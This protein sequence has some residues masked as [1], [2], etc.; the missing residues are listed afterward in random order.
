MEPSETQE[1]S[2][3]S[4]DDK[5]VE[6]VKLDKRFGRIAVKNKLLTIDQVK[7]ALRKQDYIYKKSN[8]IVLIGDLLVDSGAMGERYRDAI[9]KRQ[10]RLFKRFKSFGEIAVDKGFITT[11]QLENAL[12]IQA[13]EYKESRDV[14]ILGDI[15]VSQELIDEEQR[16]LIVME[17]NRL[18]GDNQPSLSENTDRSETTQ[19][20]QTETSEP[21]VSE[22]IQSQEPE[23]PEAPDEPKP[24]VH[25]PKPDEPEP[26]EPEF[27]DESDPHD[28]PDETEGDLT[29]LS[30]ISEKADKEVDDDDDDD[31]TGEPLPDLNLEE[32]L[33]ILISEDRLEAFLKVQAMLPIRT[34][35]IDLKHYI[36]ESGIVH[37]LVSN[38][39]L[40]EWI[41]NKQK[42]RRPLKIAQG[43]D[44][45]PPKDAR[46]VFHFETNIKKA[47]T[48]KEDGSIDFKNRGETI[49]VKKG[50]LLAE[51]IPS[52]EG[53]PGLDV[54]GK[55][56]DVPKPRDTHIKPGKGV[57]RSPDN[58]Q[59]TAAV[60]GFP[61]V[62]N[63]GKI[64]VHQVLII[65]GDVGMQ[66]GHVLFDGVVLVKGEV[67][68]GFQ[69]KAEKLEAAGIMNAE[70]TTTDDII[71]RG[72]IIGS[73]IKANGSITAKFLKASQVISKKDV[74]IEK[75]IVDSTI[76]L[77]GT[78]LCEKGKIVATQITS[79]QGVRAAEIGSETSAPCHIMVGV[80][81][82][83]QKQLKRLKNTLEHAKRDEQVDIKTE[84][85]RIT[86]RELSGVADATAD[87]V[88]VRGIIGAE[89]QT[90]GKIVAGSLKNAIIESLG[91]I[92]V[93]K[94]I[95]KTKAQ[96]GGEIHVQQGKILSSNLVALGGI[97]AHEVGTEV[98][99]PCKLVFGINETVKERLNTFSK[100]LEKKQA[101][102][103]S[104]SSLLENYHEKFKQFEMDAQDISWIKQYTKNLSGPMRRN[105]DS[106]DQVPPE[107]RMHKIKEYMGAM[108]SSMKA[109]DYTKEFRNLRQIQEYMEKYFGRHEKMRSQ[110][111][112]LEE[113]VNDLKTEIKTLQKDIKA[114]SST[115]ISN[116]SAQI[117]I[118]GRI[119]SRTDLQSNNATLVLTQDY[120]PCK[121][122]EVN[123]KIDI[124]RTSGKPDAS[125][126]APPTETK[127]DEK[128][129]D[130]ETKE[131]HVTV[132]GQVTASIS[133][134]APSGVPNVT[135]IMKGGRIQ[136]QAR[137]NN[138]GNFVI[139]GLSPGRY[140]LT[141]QSKSRPVLVQK[142]KLKDSKKV[143]LGALLLQK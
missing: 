104:S 91:H 11:E 103:E 64:N 100:S 134:M 55:V 37:G 108:D 98:S 3:I 2:N 24:D 99:A 90:R 5:M 35:L 7:E 58:L 129:K 56:I 69:V 110:I 33:K 81:S 112:N 106:L 72:G 63:N 116:P 118:F 10:N 124:Q 59:I 1:L 17:R 93:Q 87:I 123:S 71:V 140:T 19:P 73:K 45:V 70:V 47:G 30:T 74:V 16:D 142:L 39:I 92:V 117:Q 8:Y 111:T 22:V 14:T 38:K 29:Q 34:R 138:N 15:L 96:S 42:R 122:S 23:S 114:L 26:D 31:E 121:I 119:Y 54:T 139:P 65:N 83:V 86:A 126:P 120:G 62:D 115:A 60:N 143:N 105:L 132:L 95:M 49:S 9:L 137:T 50:S 41:K 128:T 57:S 25:E 27:V 48:E 141:V 101:D 76:N 77:S 36:S 82:K 20:Q 6:I 44:P 28:K 68:P 130:K 18:R 12:H 78:C 66:T 107:S 32:N 125:T 113:T 79:A 102:F 131:G 67:S 97:K 52:E 4:D 46:I 136:K 135:V 61:E 51:K 21:D 133:G 75:E 40:K 127:P 43:T 84:I 109:S 80:S 85:S 89:I 53:K 94:E 13:E 88:A